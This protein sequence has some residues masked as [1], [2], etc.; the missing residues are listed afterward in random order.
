MKENRLTIEDI[1]QVFTLPNGLRVICEQLPYLRTVS[2]GLWL[3]TG[4]MH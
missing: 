2:I 3:H 1:S 4:S